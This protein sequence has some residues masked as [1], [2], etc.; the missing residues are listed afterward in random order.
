MNYTAPNNSHYQGHT[1]ITLEGCGHT[2]FV[3]RAS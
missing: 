3:K 2:S 1:A